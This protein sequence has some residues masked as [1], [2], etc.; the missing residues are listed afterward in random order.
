MRPLDELSI[1]P[2]GACHGSDVVELKSLKDVSL[3]DLEEKI[4]RQCEYY[5]GDFNLPKDRFMRELIDQ[6]NGKKFVV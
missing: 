5:F 2:E 3:T 4:I 1:K 6:E